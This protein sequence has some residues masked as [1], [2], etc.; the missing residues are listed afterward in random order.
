M[1]LGIRYR[2]LIPL[3]LVLLGTVAGSWWSATIAARQAEARVAGQV[4]SITGTLGNSPYPLTNFVIE[5]IKQYS[6]AEFLLVFPGGDRKTTFGSQA[7]DVPPVADLPASDDT[8]LGPPVVVGGKTYR[9]RGLVL[10]ESHIDAGAS[11]Y[12]FYPESLLNEVIADAVRPALLGFVFGLL[13][14]G[15]T[16][17]L[18]DR[19][20]RRIQRLQTRTRAIAG[21]DFGPLPLPAGDDELRDLA[22]AVNEMAA[23]LATFQDTVEKTERLRFA[24]QLATG[25]AHQLR[26]GVTGARLALDIAQSDAAD[27]EALGVARRQLTL[28]EVNLRR[29]IDLNR[30]DVAKTEPCDVAKAVRDVIALLGPQAR[31]ANVA[32]TSDLPDRPVTLTGNAES[33]NDIVTNLVGNAIEAVGQNGAVTVRLSAVNGC[34]ELTVSNTGPGPPPEIA[35]KLFEP[36]VTGKS[37]G[38]G[39]GLAVVKQAVEALG[40]T[41]AW[42]RENQRTVFRVTLPNASDKA[43][44]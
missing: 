44:S 9:V 37:E 10:K 19:L 3:G 39:L 25:L 27:A 21:G 8:T 18:A 32:L 13:A 33:L 6:G 20:V 31:H 38:I 11:V 28:M 23:K 15:L 1:R 2:L 12:V 30:N 26:N 40:G 29:F 22:H 5:Q 36:F 4:R 42:T 35:M 34:D 17:F 14:V 7:V 24:G 41:I 16:Y 43:D